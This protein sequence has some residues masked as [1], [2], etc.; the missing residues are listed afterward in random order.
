MPQS[1]RSII[2]FS[3]DFS[4]A[5]S[6]ESRHCAASTAEKVS[7]REGSR[8]F[9]SIWMAE[10]NSQTERDDYGRMEAF[11]EFLVVGLLRHL[12]LNRVVRVLRCI[13]RL[14]SSAR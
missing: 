3:S 7:R 10:Y 13:T 14:L 9:E 8:W 11:R 2:D 12:E 5:M 1:R 6:E 4:T